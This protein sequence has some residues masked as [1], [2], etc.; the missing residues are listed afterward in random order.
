MRMSQFESKP[1]RLTH[2]VVKEPIAESDNTDPSWLQHTKDLREHLLRLHAT[3]MQLTTSAAPHPDLR[4]HG[5][6]AALLKH[7][8]GKVFQ[9][10]V[11]LLLP[12]TGTPDAES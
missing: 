2:L 1:S 9:L 10:L 5:E 7:L 3:C 8:Y 4:T 6:T 11:Y 12:K